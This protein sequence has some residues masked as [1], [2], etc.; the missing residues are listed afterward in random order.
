MNC[1][2]L[3]LAHETKL[4][5]A[6]KSLLNIVDTL[7]GE[8]TAVVVVPRNDGPLIEELKKRAINY[9]YVKYYPCCF[10]EKRV[11]D[12]IVAYAKWFLYRKQVNNNAVKTLI[13]IVKE[14]NIQIIHTNSGII[15]LGVRVKEQLPQI[16]HI[17]HLRE[18]LKEDQG[19]IPAY[20]WKRYYSNMKKYTDRIVAVSKAVADKF[21]KYVPENKIQVI[22][23]GVSSE[24]IAERNRTGKGV[25]NILQTGAINEYKGVG[26]SIRALQYLKEKGYNDIELYLAG[27]GN[28]DFCKKEYDK[29]KEKVHLLG[30][31]R[32]MPQLRSS[33]MDV[34]IVCSRKEAFGRVTIEA[35]LAGLPVIG[36]N[37]GGTPELIEDGVTGWIF[38]CGDYKDL[39]DKILLVYKNQKQ[40]TIVGERGK[41]TALNKFMISR[42]VKEIADMYYNVLE[43]RTN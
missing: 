40:A 29:V 6:T 38:K 19:L 3:Y 35:M 18:F 26:T 5:G 33:C 20:G 27:E 25:F 31:V 37:T 43:E 10:K 15:D 17:W 16:I 7:P 30:Y 22:Y 9:V 41:K 36:A 14:K 4:N 2:V 12:N 28:L 23:N 13:R 1:N 39:A 21:A 24:N 34:E 42:C 11:K 32:E 8:I